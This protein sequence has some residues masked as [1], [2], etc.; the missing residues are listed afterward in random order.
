MLLANLT[1]PLL[2]KQKVSKK[3]SQIYEFRARLELATCR[4]LLVAI[5]RSTAEL[6]EPLLDNPVAEARYEHVLLG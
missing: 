4:W 5:C 1:S 2:D 3:Q 6:P